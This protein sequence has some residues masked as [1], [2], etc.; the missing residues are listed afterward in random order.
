MSFC[1]YY[2]WNKKAKK[3]KIIRLQQSRTV[4]PISEQT[5][6]RILD[7]YHDNGNS[8]AI[9]AN[10][11]TQGGCL[12]D[13]ER[14]DTSTLENNNG[15]YLQDDTTYTPTVNPPAYE[16]IINRNV[17]AIDSVDPRTHRS[18]DVEGL[19]NSTISNDYV[20]TA[21]IPKVKQHTAIL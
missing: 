8:A 4:R 5:Q 16:D 21:S 19:A 13:G 9:I 15:D 2:V 7:L 20:T 17:A 10:P 1:R 6:Y 18:V 14:L 3:R 12:N 11:E